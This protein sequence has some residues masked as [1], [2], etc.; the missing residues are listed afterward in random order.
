MEFGKGISMY[1]DNMAGEKAKSA[2]IRPVLGLLR[3]ANTAACNTKPWKKYR[4]SRARACIRDAR[5]KRPEGELE[6]ERGS[7]CSY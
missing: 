3:R 7:K 6:I 4:T 2:R 5:A 1:R